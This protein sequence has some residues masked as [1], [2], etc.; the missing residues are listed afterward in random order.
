MS[1]Q[2]AENRIDGAFKR[3]FK[4]NGEKCRITLEPER[5]SWNFWDT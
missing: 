2:N 3:S 5:G 1:L 4:E